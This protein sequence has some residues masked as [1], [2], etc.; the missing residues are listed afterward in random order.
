MRIR[1]SS[2]DYLETML[3]MKE[4]H[5][6]IRSIDVA[7]QLGVTKPSVSYSVKRL[8]ENGYITMDANNLI[9]LT[10]AGMEIAERM[11]TRHKMLSEFLIRLGVDENTALEDACKIEHDL[12][13][14]TFA[15]ICKHAGYDFSTKNWG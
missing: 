6:Y 12:S 2:E 13:E 8:R 15:A 5:G 3:M 9:T 14:Q 11:L 7:M 1:K 4:K 10:D